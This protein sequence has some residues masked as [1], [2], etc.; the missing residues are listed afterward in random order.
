MGIEAPY[1]PPPTPLRVLMLEALKD[2]LR[3]SF[4]ERL[5]LRTT[6]LLGV[7]ALC[8]NTT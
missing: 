4:Q 7:G 3:E 5:S 8:A 6:W 2:C 1:R